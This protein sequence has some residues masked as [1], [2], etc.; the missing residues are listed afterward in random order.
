MKKKKEPKRGKTKAQKRVRT[1]EAVDTGNWVAGVRKKEG[2][3]QQELADRLK[4]DR[5]TL[6]SW[7]TGDYRPSAESLIR[8]GNEFSY[9]EALV[10][11]EKAGINPQK[12]EV[13]TRP[14]PG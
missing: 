13:F 1:K 12:I 14:R 2:L 3:T 8:I 7:E 4:V 9:A 5:S 6:A 11:W 10:A